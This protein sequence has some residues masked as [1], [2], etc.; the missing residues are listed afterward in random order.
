MTE[1]SNEAWLTPQRKKAIVV[2]LYIW[3]PLILISALAWKSFLNN[4]ADYLY[5][6]SFER[7]Y[8]FYMFHETIMKLTLSGLLVTIPF[9]LLWAYATNDKSAVAG[10]IISF[11]WSGVLPLLNLSFDKK[12][13]SPFLL[14]FF[15]PIVICYTYHKKGVIRFTPVGYLL[16]VFFRVVT[17]FIGTFVGAITGWV[18]T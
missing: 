16:A 13:Y 11:I 18:V 12:G 2:S 1:K 5:T 6:R 15:F 17:V 10:S 14:L 8:S 7:T 3:V 4:P 9:V